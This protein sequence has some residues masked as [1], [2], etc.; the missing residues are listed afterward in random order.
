MRAPLTNE[1]RVGERFLS[2]FEPDFFFD[3]QTR[4][5]EPASRL[6][7]TE[8]AVSGVANNMRSQDPDS[9]KN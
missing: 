8:H 3:D 5:Y 2:E 9:A 6:Q 1:W 4:R 7:P